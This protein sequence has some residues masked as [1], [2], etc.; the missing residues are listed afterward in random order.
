MTI[1]TVMGMIIRE[2][3]NDL[4][5]ESPECVNM[6]TQANTCPHRKATNRARRRVDRSVGMGAVSPKRNQSFIQE[7]Q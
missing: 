1:E 2:L 5:Y 4:E 6:Y 7:L 3:T